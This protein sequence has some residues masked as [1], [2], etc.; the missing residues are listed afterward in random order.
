MTAY[1][2]LPDRR[3]HFKNQTPSGIFFHTIKYQRILQLCRTKNKFSGALIFQSLRN[4]I[5]VGNLNKIQ[6]SGGHGTVQISYSFE[7]GGTAPNKNRSLL[8]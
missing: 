2:D 4:L 8:R 6:G 1:Y 7:F 3:C 5:F